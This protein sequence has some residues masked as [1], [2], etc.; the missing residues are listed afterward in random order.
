[1]MFSPCAELA[2]IVQAVQIVQDVG[3]NRQNKSSEF[4]VAPHFTNRF[5][6]PNSPYLP[7]RGRQKVV[8]LSLPGQR[9]SLN[10]LILKIIAVVNGAA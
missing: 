2:A 6:R 1:M 5:E 10:R 9:G 4:N 7:D 3:R 8:D